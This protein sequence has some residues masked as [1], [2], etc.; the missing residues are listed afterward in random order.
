MHIVIAGAARSGKTT[1][2]RMLK[3]K[4]FIHYKMDSIKRGVCKYFDIKTV[5]WTDFSKGVCSIIKQVMDDEFEDNII[6]DTPHICV[7]DSLDLIRDDTIVLFL[8]YDHMDF[9]TFLDNV[10]K[11]DQ[12]T[13]VGKLSM[14]ELKELFDD[15][16]KF[17]KDNREECLKYNIKYFDVSDN[18]DEVLNDACSYVLDILKENRDV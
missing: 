5:Y 12:N 2:S 7:T 4:G 13:W 6:F 10:K 1:L 16:V 15:S 9:D 11:Y 8:G 14:N 17:S 3:N 18:R